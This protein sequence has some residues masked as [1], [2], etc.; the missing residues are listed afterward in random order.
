M[1]KKMRLI[2][3]LFASCLIFILCSADSA[4]STYLLSGDKHNA[5]VALGSLPY[6]GLAEF[7]LPEATTADDVG[8]YA[9][10]VSVVPGETIDFHVSTDV[11]NFELTISRKAP[12]PTKLLT[13]PNLNAPQVSC[14]GLHADGCNWPITTSLM[15]PDDW[16]SGIYWVQVPTTSKPRNFSFIVRE[17]APGTGTDILFLS[18]VSTSNAYTGFG[19]KSLYPFN[20]TDKLRGHKVSFDRPLRTT[21]F[22]KWE[23]YFLGWGE[24]EEFGIAIAADYDLEFIPDLLENYKA[25]VIAGHSEY[26]S[27]NMRQ[28]LKNYINNGGR[29]VNL[30]GNT[31]WQQVRFE[32][33]GRIMAGFK[34]YNLDSTTAREEVTDNPID[35]PILDTEATILG[36]QWLSGGYVGPF[37]HANGFGGFTILNTEHWILEGTNVLPLDMVGRTDSQDTAVIDKEADGVHFNCSTDGQ[38]ILG[39]VRNHGTPTNFTILGMAL[40]SFRGDIGFIPMGIYTV[41]GGGAVFSA[42]T[43]G[44]A[45]ALHV[46]PAIAQITRNVLLRFIDTETPIPSEPQSIETK[47]LFHD[48]FN[49]YNIQENWPRLNVSEWQTVPV[50]NYVDYTSAEPFTL[51]PECGFDGSGLRITALDHRKKLL[52]SQVYPDWSMTDT[53]YGAMYLD[54]QE[55]TFD[56]NGFF[57]NHALYFR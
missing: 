18:S 17:K 48:R 40:S 6:E 8:G 2:S 43:T 30:S 50:V 24:R 4:I 44:W 47:Y 33:N 9:S 41:P 49:C 55:L 16:H 15:I 3:F 45:R 1:C 29:F 56:K 22:T 35:Y 14:E 28:Q 46:D 20:S 21:E 34:D 31:M 19:G 39:P 26:W 11:S 52:T 23:R 12:S 32:N 36:G 13:I 57:R 38:T 27:W 7:A 54:I 5:D 25:V 10:K 51:D 37:T 42:N 53:L